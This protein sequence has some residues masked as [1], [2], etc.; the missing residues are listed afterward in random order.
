MSDGYF[1]LDALNPGSLGSG[2]GEGGGY[3]YGQDIIIGIQPS[4]STASSARLVQLGNL[5]MVPKLNSMSLSIDNGDKTGLWANMGLQPLDVSIGVSI[6]P[7]DGTS[8][9]IQ[10]V[11]FSSGKVNAPEIKPAE[12]GSYQILYYGLTKGDVTLPKNLSDGK[13]KLTVCSK[14]KDAPE[15]DYL[16]VLCVSEGYNYGYFTKSGSTYTVE[17]LG[18]PEMTITKAS[19]VS[20]LYYRESAKVSITLTNDSEKELTKTYYPKLSSGGQTI[21]T[22]NGIT[23]SVMPN[24][25]VTEEFITVFELEENLKEP[26]GDVS[27]TLGFFD[28]ETSES[29][30]WE[31]EVTMKFNVPE[32]KISLTGLELPGLSSKTVQFEN[33]T[34]TRLYAV[35]DS[36]AIPVCCKLEVIEGYQG[37]P[38]YFAVFPSAGG[39]SLMISKFSEI[40]LLGAG[41]S[42]TLTQTIDFTVGETGKVYL[43]ALY[44]EIGGDLKQI[45]DT[46]PILF[47]VADSG[48]DSIEG[49]DGNFTVSYDRNLSLVSARSTNGM[50]SIAIFSIDGK[51]ISADTEFYGSEASVSIEDLPT[52][53]FIVKAIDKTGNSKTIKITK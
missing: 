6:E 29:Y 53:I 25:T 10:Y 34:T 11:T 51:Q 46:V 27:Y 38:I 1:L 42:M 30:N 20:D 50:A 52:G 36:S 19:I 9:T 49:V 26:T 13:Y 37:S 45:E 44:Q 2:G 31:S 39:Q 15:S 12:N 7:V 4:T 33:G 40:P 21:F 16:P 5:K 48:V 18:I 17:E 47:E 35:Y 43:I 3:N 32:T 22:A 8:G 24:E 41:E 23:V 14:T 28:P